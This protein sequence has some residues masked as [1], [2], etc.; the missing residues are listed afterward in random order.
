MTD[1]DL[2]RRYL[3]DGC[4]ASFKT[5]VERRL[6]LVYSAALRQTNNSAMAEDVTQSVFVL[7][8]KKAAGLSGKENLAGWLFNTTRFVAARAV[9]GEERRRQREQEAL[10]MRELDQTE[11]NWAGLKP[12]I[13]SAVA[14]LREPERDVLLQRFFE[15]QSVGAT[16]QALNI[17]E[18]I[19][20]KRSSAGLQRLR[21]FFSKHGFTISA[22][23]LAL[24]IEQNAIASAPAALSAAC[25]KKAA[26]GAS[27]GLVAE[28]LSAWRAATLRWLAVGA[29][30]TV[31]LFSA[32]EIAGKHSTSKA[33]D[34]HRVSATQA[35]AEELD[36]GASRPASAQQTTASRYLLFRVTDADSGAP[37]TNALLGISRV[38]ISEWKTTFESYSDPRGEFRIEYSEAVGRL[39][40]SLIVPGWE[41]RFASWRPAQD[42]PIPQVYDFRANRVKSTLG[43]KLLDESGVPI[44][45]AVM[46]IAF[47][48][49]GDYAQREAPRERPGLT[50]NIPLGK[51]DA[52][53]NWTCAI[54]PDRT[55]G[56]SINAKHPDF[57]N[58]QV[59]SVENE[60]S[61]LTSED[62][63]V[64]QLLIRS[65]VT[66]MKRGIT[67]TGRVFDQNGKTI[68]KP[69]VWR[70]RGEKATDGSD[71]GTFR[72]ASLNPGEIEFTV[73]ADGFAP[74]PLSVTIQ[75][76]MEELRVELAAGGVLRL[77]M[78]DDVGNVIPDA[79]VRL[80]SSPFDDGRPRLTVDWSAHSD[81]GGMVEWRSAP[82][83]REVEIYSYKE[84]YT[85][86]RGQRFR[87]DGESHDVVLKPEIVVAGFVVDAETG[88][89]ISEFKAIPGYGDGESAWYRGEARKC[90]NG[91]FKITLNEPN[92]LQRV[93]IEA[94]GYEPEVSEPLNSTGNGMLRLALKRKAAPTAVDGRATIRGIILD[95][96]GAPAGKVKII[97]LTLQ[98]GATLGRGQFVRPQLDLMTQSD[99]DG[100]FEIVIDPAQTACS[101]A[102][103]TKTSFGRAT[104]VKPGEQVIVRLQPFGAIKG[105][106]NQTAFKFPFNRII[107]ISESERNPGGLGID[108]SVSMSELDKEGKFILES[109]PSGVYR[110][111]IGDGKPGAPFRRAQ[112]VRVE[113]GGVSDLSINE[114]AP[115]Q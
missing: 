84:G 114:E 39:D 64:Q 100:R 61:M 45:G 53:G 102:A 96:D 22:A 32:I 56:F 91:I 80:A 33:A 34:E 10:T 13:D 35:A 36:N 104:L 115:L 97:V 5:V 17:S 78:V 21:T 74:K 77:R 55:K 20:K 110:A 92:P 9:R 12:M 60:V 11:D 59:V 8:S 99:S 82:T 44:S 93:R 4:E 112:L 42:D 89:P 68:P 58:T 95:Q 106:V 40:V 41:S 18:D 76:G 94:A 57:A 98:N 85:Q 83:D 63:N 7:L 69:H 27:S 109:L 28:T 87:A 38:L 90:A 47:N 46:S 49:S 2:L 62:K 101:V 111:F 3:K 54:A 25:L 105:R 19:V 86:S 23:A 72:I 30:V 43:G 67:L 66:R 73:G 48:G 70:S 71:E 75:P 65:L 16:A 51:T 37:L 103:V 1:G 108:S 14:T 31:A 79:D 81:A 107:V 26:A 15:G 29:V 88:K 24:A 52:Q 50:A 113:A 6:N